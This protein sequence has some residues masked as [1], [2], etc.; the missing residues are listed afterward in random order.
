M[1]AIWENGEGGGHSSHRIG[2]Y[3]IRNVKERMELIYHQDYELTI[4]S[5]EGRG[6]TVA[7][8][9]PGSLGLE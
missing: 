9:I 6:T 7:I 3:A 2:K 8:S 1:N 5:E 4:E